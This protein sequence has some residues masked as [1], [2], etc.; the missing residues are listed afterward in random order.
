MPTV[1]AGASAGGA[2]RSGL[3]LFAPGVFMAESVCP[4]IL[5][6]A[7][8]RIDDPS[9]IRLGGEG[10]SRW[11]DPAGRAGPAV[12]LE[13][14]QSRLAVALGRSRSRKRW[15]EAAGCERDGVESGRAGRRLLAVA[16]G[17]RRGGVESGC[18]RS[19]WGGAGAAA[20][21]V[22]GGVGEQSGWGAE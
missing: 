4:C 22:G 11:G 3:R 14:R 2:L 1:G 5:G 8:W 21:G 13:P 20:G 15:A 19:R 16:L 10:R 7:G 6:R 12:A 18:G 17:G 9:S